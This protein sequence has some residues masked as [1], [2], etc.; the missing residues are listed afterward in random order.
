MHVCEQSKVV[1]QQEG[2]NIQDREGMLEDLGKVK[3]RA[4]VG[5]H[6]TSV[7]GNVK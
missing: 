4:L 5:G 6:P 7:G 2:L 3:S 1:C